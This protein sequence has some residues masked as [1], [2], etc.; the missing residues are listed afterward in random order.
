MFLLAVL[1]GPARRLGPV[2]PGSRLT[3][4]VLNLGLAYANEPKQTR[5][6]ETATKNLVENRF[7]D[8]ALGMLLWLG[9]RKIGSGN[10][11]ASCAAPFSIL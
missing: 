3:R 1:A 6:I 10:F 4:A 7:M 9:Y 2:Q 8:L 11:Q 5:S